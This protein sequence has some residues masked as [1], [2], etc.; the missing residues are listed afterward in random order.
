VKQRIS[1]FF[2]VQ[3]QENSNTKLSSS[4][5]TAIVLVVTNFVWIYLLMHN[6]GM[7]LVATASTLFGLVTVSKRHP[8]GATARAFAKARAAFTTVMEKL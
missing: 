3:K 8:E 6:L 1:S 5:E 4:S 2:S 7:I